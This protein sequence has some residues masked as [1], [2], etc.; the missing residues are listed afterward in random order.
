MAVQ[1]FR[2]DLRE[3]VADTLSLSAMRVA[4]LFDRCAVT[5]LMDMDCIGARRELR[6]R[7]APEL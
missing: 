5:R 1:R 7:R 4:G 3:L 6:D 2:A